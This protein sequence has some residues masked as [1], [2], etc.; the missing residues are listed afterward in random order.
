[1]YAHK[2]VRYLDLTKEQTNK[3]QQGQQQQGQQQQKKQK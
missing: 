1:L 3:Q 2:K